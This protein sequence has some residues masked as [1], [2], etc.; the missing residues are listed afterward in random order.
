MTKRKASNQSCDEDVLF[1]QFRVD[2]NGRVIKES[3]VNWPKSIWVELNEL[4]IHES[5]KLEYYNGVYAMVSA[6]DDDINLVFKSHTALCNH[7]KQSNIDKRVHRL[8]TLESQGRVFQS[9]N[10]DHQLSSNYF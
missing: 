5:L 4:C 6:E 9:K 1:G 2:A 7:L 3:K 8:G 10:I